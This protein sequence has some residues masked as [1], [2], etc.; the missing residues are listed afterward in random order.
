M[1]A[2]YGPLYVE[3]HDPGRL[4][5]R[6]GQAEPE[7][8]VWNILVTNDKMSDQMA[9]DDRQDDVR[10]RSLS[11][12]PCTRKRRTSTSRTRPIGSPIPFHPG[13]KKYFAEKGIKV[14]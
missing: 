5:S 8:D 11:W 9:Y 2:K 13:A 3:E 1:N 7:V 10:A 12:S 6:A 4:L 14:K